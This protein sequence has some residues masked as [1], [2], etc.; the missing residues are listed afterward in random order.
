MRLAT[1]ILFALAGAIAFSVAVAVVASADAI[2]SGPARTPPPGQHPRDR[3]KADAIARSTYVPQPTASLY[4]VANAATVAQNIT[5]DPFVTSVLEGL[6]RP[7]P[8]FDPRA[9]G[10][11]VAMTPVFVRAPVPGNRDEFIGPVQAGG[12]VIGLFTVPIV[13]DGLGAAGSYQRWSGAT[14][15]AVI[16]AQARALGSTANDPV[17]SAELVWAV[18]SPL[19]GG[20]ADERSPF[21]R[22]I[23]R[24][25]A[26]VYLFE[27]GQLRLATEV[28][29]RGR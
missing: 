15:P 27:S 26:E 24:S 2:A 11:P 23:R 29:V 8:E 19:E 28:H 10:R 14:F 13:R 9:V 17:T 6:T 16:D 4:P 7:G 3:G 1:P 5:E 25:G 12:R 20:P 21:W 22:L 18:V